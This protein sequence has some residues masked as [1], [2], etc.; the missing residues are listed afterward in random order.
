MQFSYPDF[1]AA[2]YALQSCVGVV[3]LLIARALWAGAGQ[4][5]DPASDMIACWVLSLVGLM[6]VFFGFT[7]LLL[8][9]EQDVWR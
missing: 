6:C 8:R 9:N 3:F 1:K 2:L 4:S 5:A 7:T